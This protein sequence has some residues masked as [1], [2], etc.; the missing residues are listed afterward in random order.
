[1]KRKKYVRIFAIVLTLA[2]VFALAA[3]GKTEDSGTKDTPAA[4]PSDSGAPATQDSAQ[5]P[6]SP[7]SPGV[8]TDPGDAE[9]LPQSETPLRVAWLTAYSTIDPH[10]AAS[11]ADYTLIDMIY[12]SFYD[13]DQL[14]NEFPRLAES[15]E[16]SAD[17]MVY[18]YH[19][20]K[21]VKW[22][23]GGDF[24]SADVL[25]SIE[26]AGESPYMMGYL[27]S[28]ADVDAPDD[29]T[30]IFELY[31]INPAFHI[32]L[33][34]IRFL[35]EDATSGL[36]EGFGGGIPGGTGPYTL[37][38]LVMD[39]KAVFARNET[40]HGAP[41]PIGNIEIIIFSD[42]NAAVRAM[43]AGE[44]DYVICDGD[45]WERLRATGKYN[46]YT[47]DTITIR[48]F[49]MNNECEPFDDP[50]V[51]QAINYAVNKE[52]FIL[53]SVG[54]YGSPAAYLAN[55]DFNTAA[56]RYDEI[57]Q[58][59]YDPAKARELLAEAGYEDGLVIDEPI[60]TAATDEFAIPAQ[61]LKEQLA[62]VGIEIDIMTVELDTLVVDLILGNYGIGILALGLEPDASL[63]SYAYITGGHDYLNLARYSNDDVD[64][65]FE[66]GGTTLDLA[67]R[68]AYYKEALD[69]ASREAAYLPLYVLQA[70]VATTPGLHSTSYRGFYH[71]YWD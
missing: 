10:Y 3:C 9:P 36:D 61:I 62:A 1:M 69:I 53:G 14:G 54:G 60:L 32:E 18:T 6:D 38:S 68:K 51:R 70:T 52:D 66:L 43:E 58:Y 31:D 37:A 40:Y 12:E 5:N 65:L 46:T 35:S 28:V 39:Q 17:G 33:S 48:F 56:P 19:L 59:S 11:D 50:L 71:W 67:Q 27:A 49:A 45:N 7:A 20:K 22:Q 4:S 34:R 29:Y 23:T 13:I 21:G 64:E 8:T 16:V 30:V 42:T 25:Y 57:F 15:Y 55:P 63:I 47:E 26:R 2:L 24:T 44:C 41:A